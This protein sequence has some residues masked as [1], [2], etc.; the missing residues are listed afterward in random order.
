MQRLGSGRILSK[1]GP[2]D[3]YVYRPVR[4]VA[5]SNLPSPRRISRRRRQRE[6]ERERGRMG[7][8][9]RRGGK[10]SASKGIFIEWILKLM[11]A[12]SDMLIR[13][14][15]GFLITPD[16]GP[17]NN[18][19]VI[20]IEDAPPARLL[21]RFT[22]VHPRFLSPPSASLSFLSNGGGE[23]ILSKPREQ[24]KPPFGRKPPPRQQVQLLFLA[25]QSP[26]RHRGETRK[27]R[28]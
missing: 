4:L 13:R 24:T 2:C 3:P 9:D 18:R 14:A 22:Y 12:T 15:S 16:D 25:L 8:D 5:P 1:A 10:K 28:R 6:R 27:L 11:V 26:G 19:R 17:R 20:Q 21:M 23:V 7:R